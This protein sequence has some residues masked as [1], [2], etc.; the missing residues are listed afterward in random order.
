ML[1]FS[2]FD[3]NAPA[4]MQMRNLISRCKMPLSEDANA[5]FHDA[6]VHCRDA[7]AKFI[8]DDVNVSLRKCRCDFL[9]FQYKV[10]TVG[11]PWCKYPF[12]GMSW[13]K[14]QL[15]KN[16]LL[17]SRL[18]RSL[19]LKC[20]QNSIY[21]FRRLFFFYFDEAWM[22]VHHFCPKHVLFWLKALPKICDHY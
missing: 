15:T 10:P 6:S 16:F 21:F 5:S 8:H 3:T 12:V 13:C 20:F 4:K 11:M 2:F 9:F 1:K 18:P 17:L 22:L 19:K 14:C 7:D